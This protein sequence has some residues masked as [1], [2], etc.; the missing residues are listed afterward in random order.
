MRARIDKLDIKL[1]H[2]L[3][4]DSRLTCKE[5]AEKLGITRQ[6]VARRLR[7]LEKIGVIL[8]YTIIPDFDKLEYIYVSLGITLEPGAPIDKIVQELKK[9]RDV[10]VI[11]RGIGG[12]NL[13]VRI[14]VPK[15]MEELEKKINAVIE[16]I[17]HVQRYDATI[18]TKTEKFEIL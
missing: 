3:A 15:K 10:K 16:K 13:V 7:K 11:E 6:S 17:G 8:K 9:D 5:L 4:E 18:I 12:H 14:A 1:I 2:I